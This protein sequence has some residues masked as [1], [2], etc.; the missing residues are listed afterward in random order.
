MKPW[1]MCARRVLPVLE[2]LSAATPFLIE[3]GVSIHQWVCGIAFREL[4]LV[5][6]ICAGCDRW[7]RWH[8]G[9][10]GDMLTEAK[11][12]DQAEALRQRLA[13]QLALRMYCVLDLARFGPASM[14]KS[15]PWSGD[16]AQDLRHVLIEHWQRN[17]MWWAAEYGERHTRLS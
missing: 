6:Q 14:R 8:L 2:G 7:S 11:E 10:I 12:Q 5:D 4:M 9:S 1:T 17:G 3:E 13:T 15:I 16:V